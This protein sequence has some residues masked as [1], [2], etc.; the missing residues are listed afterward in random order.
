M[1]LLPFQAE[2]SAKIAE[3]FADYM[4]DPLTVRRTQLVPFYQNLSSIT[5]SGKTLILADSIEA[6]RSRLPVE[7]IV[8]WLSKG[9]VVVWQTFANLSTGKYADLIGGF[10][11]KPL[12]DCGPGD[13]E[14]AS[15]G[16]L[17]VATVGKFNQRDKDEGDRKIFRVQLDVADRSLWDL[18]KIRQDV[19][20]RRRPLIIVYDEGHNLSNLQT[21]LLLELEPDALIA[22]SATMRIPEALAGTIERLRRDKQWSDG[23]FVTAVRS[24]EV[25]KSGL[26]KRHIMLGGYV[27][28]ME[29]A[30]NDLLAE[31]EDAN[32]SAADL[33]LPFRP[34]AI[35]VS[36]TNSVDGASTK[37]DMG[38]PFRERQARPILIWRHLVENAG[39]DPATI[40]VYCDLKF[41]QK[42]PPPSQFNLFAQ[43]DS[44]YDRFIAGN[45][46]HVIFNLSLQEGW[47][48]PEC[49]FAYIDK[50]MGSP[51]QVT[52][53][54]GRVLRQPGGQHYE[55]P[56]LNTAHFYIRTDE[57]GVFE[58]ILEDVRTRL[59]SDSPEIT[60]TVRRE[61]HGGSKLYRPALKDRS[62]PTASI[63]S[64]HAI[65]EINKIIK[66]TQDYSAGGVNTVGGGGRIQ[67]LQTI[68][69]GES[70]SVEWA[71]V[72]HSNRVTARWILRREIQRLF[73]SHG[74][75]QRSPVNLCDIE[76]TKFDALVEYNSLAAEHIREQARK[77]VDAYIE[78]SVIV[79]NALDHPYVVPSIPI[80]ET[81][82]VA[83]TNALHGGYSGLNRDEL[84]FAKA[85]DKSKRVWC[86]NPSLGGFGVPL[87]DRGNTR[88]FYPDF[89]AWTDKTVVAIDTKGD[90]LITEDAGRKLFYIEKIEDGPEL[91]I[92]LVTR[93]E[94]QVS[95]NGVYGKL[96]GSEGF[97]VWALKQGKP[98]PMRCATIA[99]TVQLCLRA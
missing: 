14:D 92:R 98:H 47:D 78:H 15:R 31:M 25:V 73:P 44:D 12:L 56:I 99:E 75:R 26:V 66:A 65:P 91:V 39:I 88:T 85:L 96:S 30:V 87:L 37:D 90:H 19:A 51:D 93:G 60:L 69:V 41:D 67:V 45:Y 76:D 71:E 43:G 77:V 46:R 50:D 63:D 40:A 89:L 95:Q 53:V 6:I 84:A 20:K 17:L 2:A 36:T 38:R 52:Q 58:A 82:F 74:D 83:F 72:D 61:T 28:P 29:L 27:T 86:R 22:A 1:D 24:S 79:Q 8:L 55:S 5:G 94:W 18:L 97:T 62:V 21:Q 59:A 10:A 80:D 57:K 81:G 16:L 33:G 48:D 9:K 54:V 32:R 13:V 42:M 3:R 64:T 7:P 11:V 70:A 35:Y 49:A 4:A 68:G 23:D 34:K